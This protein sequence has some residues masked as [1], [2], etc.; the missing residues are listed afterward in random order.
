MLAMSVVARADSDPQIIVGDPTCGDS[1]TPVGAD[2]SF[3]LPGTGPFVG[4]LTFQNESGGTWFSLFLT[5]TAVPFND[6]SCGETAYF[7][8]CQVIPTIPSNPFASTTIEFLNTLPNPGTGIPD[9]GVFTLGFAGD[10]NGNWQSGT[11]FQG[12]ATVTFVPEPS[13]KVLLLVE[14]LAFLGMGIVIFRRKNLLPSFSSS[15]R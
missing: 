3:T 7:N 4:T 6:V 12:H 13:T 5:E 15:I 10:G 9:G 1:C 8:F 11:D 14:I 2:F